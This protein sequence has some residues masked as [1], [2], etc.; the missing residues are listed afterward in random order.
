MELAS[1]SLKDAEKLPKS[2]ANAEKSLEKLLAQAK[3]YRQQVSPGSSHNANRDSNTNGNQQATKAAVLRRAKPH[4]KEQSL[5]FIQNRDSIHWDAESDS[6]E[7][8]EHQNGDFVDVTET[9]VS[10]FTVVNKNHNSIYVNGNHVKSNSQLSP[11]S[12]HT[13]QT[14]PNGKVYTSPRGEPS[15]S[16]RKDLEQQCQKLQELQRH[17]RLTP[18]GTSAKQSSHSPASTVVTSVQTNA[19]TS[20]VTPTSSRM[21]NGNGIKP[22]IAPKPQLR[23]SLNSIVPKSSQNT[24]QDYTSSSSE[25]DDECQP[26]KEPKSTTV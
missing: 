25:S 24:E 11:V 14:I 26:I 21:S 1:K 8:C 12:S 13:K 4:L 18:T 20:Y 19:N 23:T 10:A 16:R 9:A 15:E 5:P 7:D 6:D 2:D 3:E 22:V 17:H